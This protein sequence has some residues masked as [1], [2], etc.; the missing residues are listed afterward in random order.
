MYRAL[1]VCLFVPVLHAQTAS[2]EQI[3]PAANRAVA[4]VQRGSTTFSKL[5][6][7]F[8]CHD[9]A[10]PMLTL[11]MARQ[12]GVAVDE[13]A[14][15]QVAAKGFLS[16]PDLT[17]IDH[18]VQDN[19][20]IDPAASEG[21]ALIA[22]HAVGVQPN[23]VT[24][25]YA[26]RIANWQRPEGNWSTGD[27]RPPQSSSF[28][29][30]T[31]VALRAMRFYMPEQL[32]KE[33]QERQARAIKWLLKAEPQSTEDATFRLFG[34]YWA[35]GAASEC[36]RAAQALL[37]L[38]RPDGG[39]AE[40]PHMVPDAYSTGQ[41]L[42]AL[43]EAGGISVTNPAWP[44]GCTTCSPRSNPMAHGTSTRGWFRQPR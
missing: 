37:A 17:S 42:V 32:A 11:S 28:F 31:A 38:Q 33:T 2:P 8:S 14:A 10:L 40:L 43:H 15:G 34:L 16:S 22:A 41:A 20:I 23:L 1:L 27:G 3:R 4:I 13:A 29:T 12:R 9:H 5:M 24:A 44:K 6:Q 21:W 39:W 26:R 19:M 35:G 30:T 7:C 36:R 25:V 18:A